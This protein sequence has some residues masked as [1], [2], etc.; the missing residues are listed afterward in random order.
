MGALHRGHLEL[1]RIAKTK[2][3]LCV[4][5]IFVNPTQFLAGE[6]L[7]RYPKPIEQDIAACESMDVDILFCPTVDQMYNK[8]SFIGFTIDTLTDNLCGKTRP[9]HF[10]GVIQIVNKLFNLVQP[11][12]AVFG[13]KDYQQYRIIEQMVEEYMH[14]VKLLMAPIIRDFDG[15]ALS[16]RNRYLSAEERNIANSLYKALELIKNTVL[17]DRRVE[18][19]HALEILTKAG[20]KIDYI[21][22]YDAKTLQPIT[23]VKGNAKCVVAGAVYVG[24]TRL[25]DNL[26]FSY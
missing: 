5:S 3:D 15:L 16:S 25:I 14:P 12:M 6:D 11:N 21:G 18:L 9:G 20:L 7:D 10:E 2:V 4:V 1:I 23:S 24:K 17:N 22:L 26:L 13:Q 8:K 19:N